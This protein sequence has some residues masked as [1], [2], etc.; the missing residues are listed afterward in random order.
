[1]PHLQ[2]LVSRPRRCRVDLES[3]QRD[4]TTVQQVVVVMDEVTQ[5][6][7]V[8]ND[9]DRNRQMVRDV[10]NPGGVDVAG[11]S[12][13]FDATQDGGACEPSLVRTM[14]DHV[15]QR[16][17]LVNRVVAYID[18]QLARLLEAAHRVYQHNGSWTSQRGSAR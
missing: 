10:E 1:M 3:V 13:S 5:L 14:H 16:L 12:E 7:V 18:R 11:P 9:D 6:G 4:Q 17:V 8:I 15:T 2:V